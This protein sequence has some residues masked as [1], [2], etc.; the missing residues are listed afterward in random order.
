VKSILSFLALVGC[1]CILGCGPKPDPW[2]LVSGTVKVE[3]QPLIVGIGWITYYPDESKGNTITGLPI[4]KIQTDG[5]YAL[6][7][8]GKQGAPCGFYKVVVAATRDPLPVP[9]PPPPWKP[10]W[11]THDKYTQPQT[12]DVFVEVTE[13]PVPGAYDLNLARGESQ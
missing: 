7:T 4:G 2:G 5:S 8:F 11:L 12:T 3:G 10:A 6:T 1:L 13:K 9:M